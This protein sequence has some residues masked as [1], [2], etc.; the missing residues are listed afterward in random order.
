MN[1]GDWLNGLEDRLKTSLRQVEPDPRFVSGLQR[2]LTTPPA[3]TIERRSRLSALLVVNLGLAGGV[4]VFWLL[5]RLWL[6]I[7]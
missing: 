5:R 2:R 6:G 1:D 3:I 4:L 7:R